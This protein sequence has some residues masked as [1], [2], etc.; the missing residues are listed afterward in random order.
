MV[1]YAAH[2]DGVG[3]IPPHGGLQADGVAT[4]EGTGR[5]MGLPPSGVFDGRGGLEGV[6]YLSLL[7]PEHS[8]AV[9]C[10]QAN[11]GPVSGVEAEAGSK[12]GKEMVGTGGFEFRVNTDGGPGGRIDGGG[13]DTDE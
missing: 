1:T 12:C 10:N 6:G 7:P 5:R 13:G 9:Y 8:F 2:E 11:Y 4:P 3:R